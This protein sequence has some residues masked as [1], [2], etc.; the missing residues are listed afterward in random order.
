MITMIL[1]QKGMIIKYIC[2]TEGYVMY[3]QDQYKAAKFLDISVRQLNMRMNY[4]KG[5]ISFEHYPS[6]SKYDDDKF[7]DN[8]AYR[9]WTKPIGIEFETFIKDKKHGRTSDE[10]RIKRQFEGTG[11]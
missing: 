5:V 4:R 6:T 9:V 1:N 2:N 7:V 3:F 10:D 11:Y 8:I